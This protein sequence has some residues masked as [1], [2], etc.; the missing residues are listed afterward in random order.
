MKPA[1]RGRSARQRL[2]TDRAVARVREDAGGIPTSCGA[3][4]TGARSRPEPQ[5]AAEDVPLQ[6]FFPVRVQGSPDCRRMARAGT[7]GQGRVTP[8][9]GRLAIPLS[10]GVLLGLA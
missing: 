1:D 6:A 3:S 9:E 2:F 7:L 4:F 5:A 8:E 10:P